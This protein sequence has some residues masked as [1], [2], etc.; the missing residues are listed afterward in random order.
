MARDLP[1]AC[2]SRCVPPAAGIMPRLISGCPNV[3]VGEAR[4]MSHLRGRKT[5]DPQNKCRMNAHHCQ[6]APSP[7]LRQ[8]ELSWQLRV[9]TRLTA[10][11]L[12][13]AITGFLICVNRVQLF[14]KSALYTSATGAP[15]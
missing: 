11:P 12:T 3:A 7:K 6:F 14:R 10:Y 13:A 5:H 2:V 1:M 15:V 4:M 9:S 8:D